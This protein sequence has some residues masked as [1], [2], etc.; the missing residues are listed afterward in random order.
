[1]AKN[2]VVRYVHE[3]EQAA[4]FGHVVLKTRNPF[5]SRKRYGAPDVYDR[6]FSKVGSKHGKYT[7]L[8]AELVGYWE[9]WP[10]S[11]RF[12]VSPY[13]DRNVTTFKA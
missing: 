9:T 7:R 4:T 13:L 11:K 6:T 8:S 5:Y 3:T 12:V 10:T 2:A 1:M